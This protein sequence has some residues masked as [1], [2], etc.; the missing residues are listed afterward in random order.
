MLCVSLIQ[1]T[2]DQ[3]KNAFKNLKFVEIRLDGVT[4]LTTE[5]VRDLF[6]E[7]KKNNIQSIVTLRPGKITEEFRQQ[8]LTTAIDAGATYIDLEIESAEDFKQP[9]IDL[10]KER[11]CRVIISYH[12]YTQT[13]KLTELNQIIEDAIQ[14]GA[15][16][17]K[18]A[19][20]VN[21]PYENGRLLGLLANHKMVVIGMG[22]LG[23]ITRIAAPIIGAPFTFAAQEQGH[24]TAPGQFSCDRLIEIWREI[25]NG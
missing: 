4:E 8:L 5:G 3:L 9:L 11:E 25:A 6:F 19:T 15:D 16:L 24:L 23:Q 1:P 7:I 12:N 2:F 21:H 22:K 20:M 13:P 14:Q 18:I 17:V 10:A